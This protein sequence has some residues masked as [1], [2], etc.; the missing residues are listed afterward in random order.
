MK[1]LLQAI[2][3]N[4]FEKVNELLHVCDPSLN[5]NEAIKVA[6]ELGHMNIVEILIK[7]TRV[8]PADQNN[9]GI[10]GAASYGHTDTVAVLLKD[11]RVNPADQNNNALVWAAKNGHTNTV[12]TLMKDTRVNPADINKFAIRWAAQY[13]HTNTVATLIKDNRVNPVDAIKFTNETV[14]KCVIQSKKHG[15]NIHTQIYEQHQQATVQW[16][17]QHKQKRKKSLKAIEWSLC[18]SGENDMYYNIKKFI[19]LHK[20]E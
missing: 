11:T 3:N 17:L 13:G 8:N 15:Y 20:F 12:A 6:A 5:D 16:F 4:E 9:W 10:R 14:W 7:D 1:M 19:K 18:V 2:R